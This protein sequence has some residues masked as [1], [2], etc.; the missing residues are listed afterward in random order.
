MKALHRKYLTALAVLPLLGGLAS[1]GAEADA[2]SLTVAA[3]S[4]TSQS[5]AAATH[6]T[7]T[8]LGTDAIAGAERRAYLKFSVS[9][10]PVGA[11]NVTAA[12]RIYAQSASAATFTV[13]TTAPTWTE[14]ALTW[15]NQPALGSKV[16]SKVGVKTG[17]NDLDVSWK[18]T[19]NGTYSFVVRNSSTTQVNF[20]SKDSTSSHPAQ[21]VLSWTPA[22]GDPVLGTAGDIAC[23]PGGTVSATSCQQAATAALLAGSDVTVVQTLGDE[24]YDSGTSAEFTGGYD[25]SWGLLKDKT[26]PAPGNHEYLTSGATGYFGYFGVSAGVPSEGYYSYDLGAWHIVVLNSEVPNGAGSIQ[27]TWFRSDLAAHP[28]LCTLALWHEPYISASDATPGRQALFQ[29]AYNGG[30]DIVLNGHAHNY[31]RFAP[32]TPD[33]KADPANGVREF[34]VGTGGK[35]LWG[36]TTTVPTSQVRNSTTFGVLKLTLHAGSYDWRFVP[37]AGSTFTDSGSGTCH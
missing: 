5:S 8:Y 30:V 20:T 23:A 6:G 37:I 21:L 22:T 16:T 19:A 27:E 35:S 26:N 32:Q 10:I 33:G 25:L 4:Y 34:V 36:F 2:A 9:S 14:S 28:N 7:V 31:Q 15:N 1:T 12:L 24:Q 13:Y 3:D 18:V 29:D 11:T 17:I